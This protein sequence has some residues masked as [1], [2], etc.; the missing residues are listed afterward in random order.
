VKE[1]I[2]KVLPFSWSLL[3]VCKAGRASQVVEMDPGKGAC[4]R[5]D[6][7]VQRIRVVAII[8]GPKKSSIHLFYGCTLRLQW[9]PVWF[10]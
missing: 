5:F 2:Y 7:F 6:G 4:S 1:I 8:R 10:E 3:E 9:D